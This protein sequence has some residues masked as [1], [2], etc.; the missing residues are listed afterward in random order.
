LRLDKITFDEKIN[1][2]RLKSL[3]LNM[4]QIEDEDR[5]GK[6]IHIP[7]I[8]DL[9]KNQSKEILIHE[10][11]TLRDRLGKMI[12]NLDHGINKFKSL[13]FAYARQEDQIPNQHSYKMNNSTSDE[14]F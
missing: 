11:T 12:T 3:T 1:T 6:E 8:E 2:S 4:T 10:N 14:D 13:S 5:N 9:F 7:R